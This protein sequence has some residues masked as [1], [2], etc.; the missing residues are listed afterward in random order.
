VLGDL[1]E[2]KHAVDSPVGPSSGLGRVLGWNHQ[3]GDCVS[4]AM[5]G[6]RR[7]GLAALA[8]GILSACAGGATE[9]GGDCV[10]RY[11][12]VA[13]ATTWDGLKD[14]MLRSDSKWGYVA[15]LRTRS[16]GDDVGAG[17]QEAVR[18]VDLLNRNGRRLLQVDVWRT[19]SGGW[20]A[21]AWSQCID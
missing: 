17:D 9:E 10:S 7:T 8:C 21:G 13:E 6:S 20:R 14:A 2:G 19:D 12:R 18:V 16:R 15:S 5:T 11:D 3:R 4:P 1:T